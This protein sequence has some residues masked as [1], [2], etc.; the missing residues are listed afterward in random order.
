MILSRLQKQESWPSFIKQCSGERYVGGF[1]ELARRVKRKEST[2]N[3]H[4]TEG[5][6]KRRQ[7]EVK[8]RRGKETLSFKIQAVQ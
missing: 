3:N 2:H 8:I 1:W 6:R 7:T 5:R 4:N